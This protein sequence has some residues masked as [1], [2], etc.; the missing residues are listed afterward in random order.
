LEEQSTG[1]SIPPGIRSRVIMPLETAVQIT[2]EGFGGAKVR[3]IL[4]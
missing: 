2:L 1:A 4:E 3:L